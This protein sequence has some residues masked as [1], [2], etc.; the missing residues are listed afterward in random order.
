MLKLTFDSE[1]GSLVGADL[2]QH[3]AATHSSKNQDVKPLTLLTQAPNHT[4][5]AQTGLIGSGGAL[6]TKPP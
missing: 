3:L 2:L 4:Y 1:G 6:P 5:V